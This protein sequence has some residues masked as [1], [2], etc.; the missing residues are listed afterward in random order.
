VHAG[1]RAQVQHPVGRA[2]GVF[3]V[4][5][6]EHRVAQVAQAAQRGDQ[7]VVVALVQADAGLVQHVHHAREAGADLRGQ[8]DALGLATRQRVR[9]A[10]Q[11]QVVQAHI[12]EEA[13][14]RGDLA[15]DLVAD[16][17]L[18]A[19]ELQALEVVQAFAQRRMLDLVD[20]PPARAGGRIGRLQHHVAGLA[21][22]A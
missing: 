9:A 4:L 15:D 16:V 8:A 2:D 20:R 3:V 6:H 19:L 5:H 1:T 17:G 7:A 11:A 14:P 12:V 22:Q 13:Q 10:V 18:V 21:A